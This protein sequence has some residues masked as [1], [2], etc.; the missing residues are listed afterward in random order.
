MNYWE[1]LESDLIEQWEFEGKRYLGIYVRKEFCNYFLVWSEA[2]CIFTRISKSGK[3][4]QVCFKNVLVPEKEDDVLNLFCKYSICIDFMGF[5][6]D[7]CLKL[8]RISFQ[9][10]FHWEEYC[11][12]AFRMYIFFL[13]KCSERRMLKYKEEAAELIKE[14]SA[15]QEGNSLEDQ[16]NDDELESKERIRLEE[17]VF[18]KDNIVAEWMSYSVQLVR[19]I[20][21]YDMVDQ[22]YRVLEGRECILVQKFTFTRS[23][24]AE[25]SF[26]IKVNSKDAYVESSTV[27]D[28]LQKYYEMLNYAGNKSNYSTAISVIAIGDLGQKEIVNNTTETFIHPK[29]IENW[30][31]LRN[32]EK[33]N[34]D[35][36]AAVLNTLKHGIGIIIDPDTIKMLSSDPRLH[37][38][39]FKVRTTNGS[40]ISFLCLKHKEMQEVIS[41]Q[42]LLDYFWQESSNGRRYVIGES[43]DRYPQLKIKT[44]PFRHNKN[45]REETY[46]LSP[47]SNSNYKNIMEL[48]SKG[49]KLSYDDFREQVWGKKESERAEYYM[50]IDWVVKHQVKENQYMQETIADVYDKFLL[51]IY[52]ECVYEA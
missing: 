5:H 20:A 52:K 37:G 18:K 21:F 4:K 33:S 27:L 50:L 30:L 32:K 16:V 31:K 47:I 6:A 44:L 19:M 35:E 51:D 14:K 24:K 26:A 48:K 22:P 42:I 11:Y 28:A 45:R 17:E 46:L 2:D 34:D 15:G 41:D 8:H 12:A 49:R 1:N 10:K 36:I 29:K 7:N 25:N 3:D 43:T 40:V 38:C 39:P 23:K 13:W 9:D